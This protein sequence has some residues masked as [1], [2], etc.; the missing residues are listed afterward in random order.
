MF[1]NVEL[2]QPIRKL[3]YIDFR[4]IHT[5]NRKPAQF[6]DRFYLATKGLINSEQIYEVIV[7]SK[8]PT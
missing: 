1:A 4:W 7:S 8:I 2:I 6:I 5:A 3:I